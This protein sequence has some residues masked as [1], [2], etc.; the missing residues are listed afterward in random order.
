MFFFLVM[1]ASA[2]D[3]RE[4]QTV[5]ERQRERKRKR[6]RSGRE[7]CNKTNA[8]GTHRKRKREG[9]LEYQ[10]PLP[11]APVQFAFVLLSCPLFA[12]VCV[13][14]VPAVGCMCVGEVRG[15]ILKTH[16]TLSVLFPLFLASNERYRDY[17]EKL[18]CGGT[19]LS[20]CPLFRCPELSDRK[21]HRFL[22]AT[23]EHQQQQ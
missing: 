7:N 5:R 3:L 10:L 15:W 17:R 6:G 23:A 18:Q 19:R 21:K 12:L 20:A 2:R 13:L 14:I 9:E 22:I 16:L 1:G 4:I 8:M 11:F